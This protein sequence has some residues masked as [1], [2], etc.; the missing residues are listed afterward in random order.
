MVSTA[1]DDWH[2]LEALAGGRGVPVER[3][4]ATGGSRLRIQ[5]AGDG[6]IGLLEERGSAHVDLLDAAVDLLREAWQAGLPRA[7]GDDAWRAAPGTTGPASVVAPAA[8]A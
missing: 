5:L 3:L 7:L 8:D 4:G 2:R 6:A 1:P